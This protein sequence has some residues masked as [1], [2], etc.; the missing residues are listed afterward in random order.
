MT[1][2]GTTKTGT[3]LKSTPVNN[4]TIINAL[5][6][7]STETGLTKKNFALVLGNPEAG[8]GLVGVIK[9]SGTNRTE[10]AL[11][12]APESSGTQTAVG[13]TLRNG[14]LEVRGALLPY[15]FTLPGVWGTETGGSLAVWVKSGTNLKGDSLRFVGGQGFGVGATAFQGTVKTNGRDI[16]VGGWVDWKEA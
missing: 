14:E 8:I 3:A 4:E 10:V 11:L 6:A 2:D 7:S 5:L 13:E 12:G 1:T 15:D 9:I 16:R